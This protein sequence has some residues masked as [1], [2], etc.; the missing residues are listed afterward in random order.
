MLIKQL[1]NYNYLGKGLR[2]ATVAIFCC[3]AV[4]FNLTTVEQRGLFKHQATNIHC[5]VF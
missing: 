1:L 5:L 3:G 4:V 2:I